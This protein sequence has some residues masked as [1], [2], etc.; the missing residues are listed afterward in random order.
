[1][2]VLDK[3]RA[4][5][6]LFGLCRGEKTCMEMNKQSSSSA[7]GGGHAAGVS[8]RRGQGFSLAPVRTVLSSFGNTIFSGRSLRRTQATLRSCGPPRGGGFGPPGSKSRN[9]KGSNGLE[10]LRPF[11]RVFFSE[12]SLRWHAC[13]P[14][15]GGGCGLRALQEPNSRE[16][17]GLLQEEKLRPDRTVWV[18]SS[19]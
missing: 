14:P 18:H 12:R 5:P 7:A 8:R 6:N 19:G 9:F 17:V 10:R 2:T 11:Y 1:M 13:G 15:P 16:A 3:P 4:K